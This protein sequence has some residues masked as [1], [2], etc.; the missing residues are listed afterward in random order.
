MTKEQAIAAFV[1]LPTAMI[2]LMLLSIATTNKVEVE[3][4]SKPKVDSSVAPEDRN[5]GSI[6]EV[7]C[8]G[9]N[10]TVC[11]V[12]ANNLCGEGK[13][14]PAA[15]PGDQFPMGRWIHDGGCYTGQSMLI[16]CKSE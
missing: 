1:G 8:E 5:L 10:F 6:Q 11:L 4:I 14:V 7:T 9:V 12:H 3:A 15:Y 16:R 2:A 13:W